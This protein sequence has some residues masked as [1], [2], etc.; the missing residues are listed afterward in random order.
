MNNVL[1]NCREW[2]IDDQWDHGEFGRHEVTNMTDL[3]RTFEAS[4]VKPNIFTSITEFNTL[5]GT[6]GIPESNEVRFCNWLDAIRNE[7]GYWTSASG[8]SFPISVKPALA[9]SNNLRH[10]AKCL[11][12]YFLHHCF[13]YSD[14]AI[15]N[16]IIGFQLENGA[17]P[18]F[19]GSNEDLWGTAY[20]VN[21][22]IRASMET[23]L[24]LTVPQGKSEK[25]WKNELVLRLER[26]VNWLLSQLNDDHLWEIPKAD[27]VSVS[28]AM[29]AE[30]GGY[31]AINKKTYC[32]DII[33][34]MLD[35]GEPSAAVIY[36]AFLTLDCLSEDL[37]ARVIEK[38]D[39][40]VKQITSLPTEMLSVSALCKLAYF[41]F[42]AGKIIYY[43]NLA[44]GHE[45][46]LVAKEKWKQDEYFEW[47]I[48]HADCNKYAEGICFVPIQEAEFWTYID[49]LIKDVKQNT[50][51]SRGWELLWNEDTPVNEK[52]VQ[53]YLFQQIDAQ[54]RARSVVVGREVET[55][56]GPVDFSFV[57]GYHNRCILEIK[58]A[59][60]HAL[61]SGDFIAQLYDYARGQ[62]VKSAFLVIIGFS[63]KEKQIISKVDTHIT[64]FKR[65]HDDFY[66]S[67]QYIDA[68]K[69]AGASKSKL[70]DL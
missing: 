15:F 14:A 61:Q 55:G 17:Y 36:S 41:D 58:L 22:L 37:Q 57:N 51:Y 48:Q 21:L 18:Q 16:A 23:N 62:K 35:H 70:K 59:N 64:A 52:K 65:D 31:L 56:R 11:D 3:P 30:I 39:T 34:A 4:R 9:N 50:E 13:R 68:S 47:A 33:S 42:S 24:K 53:A 28:V 5:I 10:T 26:A 69:K 29:M 12:Q 60:H 1:N 67:M 43:R 8:V 38:C 44:N 63:E 66:I 20:F 27:P 6:G 40:L 45:S 25:D 32:Q 19:A 49:H 46:M 54:C 7:N 2:L